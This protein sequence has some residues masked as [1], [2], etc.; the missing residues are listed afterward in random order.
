M[1]LAKPYPEVVHPGQ[2]KVELATEG[3]AFCSFKDMRLVVP[4]TNSAH[5]RFIRCHELLHSA[6]S[7]TGGAPSDRVVVAVEEARMNSVL[8]RRLGVYLPKGEPLDPK[9]KTALVH[10]ASTMEAV[11]GLLALTGREEE[12]EAFSAYLR[13]THDEALPV[14]EQAL[15]LLWEGVGPGQVPSWHA[16]LRVAAWLRGEEPPPPPPPEE[17]LTPGGEGPAGPGGPELEEPGEE[18]LPTLSIVPLPRGKTIPLPGAGPTPAPSTLEHVWPRMEVVHA[19]LTEPAVDPKMGRRKRRAATEGAVPRSWH[20]L[21][22]DGAIFDTRRRG[23][24]LSVLVDCSGSMGLRYEELLAFLLEVPATT[25][26]V[27]SGEGRDPEKLVVLSHKGRRVNRRDFRRLVPDDMNRMDLPALLWLAKQRGPRLWISD[28]GVSAAHP[29]DSRHGFRLGENFCRG[30]S[31]DCL[32]ALARYK[33][34]QCFDVEEALEAVQTRKLPTGVYLSHG[35]HRSD[36][37][38]LELEKR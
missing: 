3:Q 21:V 38:A 27:Y 11:L 22:S 5:H 16:T 18:P 31:L 9:F 13:G 4:M 12:F 17:M 2:W 15:A 30:A 8:E 23:R 33:I 6:L 19:P 35:L 1:S 28:G 20:R 32:M 37:E 26:A 34:H 25:L 14:A 29:G 24:N 7:P 10:P 36:Y